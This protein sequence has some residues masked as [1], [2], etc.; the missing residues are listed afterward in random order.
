MLKVGRMLKG[1]VVTVQMLVVAQR[2]TMSTVAQMQT[3]AEGMRIGQKKVDQRQ[4]EMLPVAR[5]YQK[6]RRLA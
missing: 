2:P 4:I 3:G 5:T 1:S 6:V